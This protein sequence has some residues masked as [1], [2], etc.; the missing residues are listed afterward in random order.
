MA[1]PIVVACTHCGGN[2]KLKDASYVGKKIRCPKCQEPFVVKAAAAGK[3]A[4]GKSKQPEDEFGFLQG[5][6]E[7]DYEAP[8][9]PEGEA[10]EEFDD[11]PAT[12]SRKKSAGGKGKTAKKKRRASSGPELGRVAVIA[13]LIVL[14][15]L[16][17]GGGV[18]GVV[19]LV[20]NVGGGLGRLAWLPEDADF[21]CEVKVSELWNSPVLQPLTSGPAGESLAEQWK[22]VSKINITDIDRVVAGGRQSDAAPVVVMYAKTDLP[23][24]EIRKNTREVQHGGHTLY[25]DNVG[26]AGGFLPNGK[27][28]VYGPEGRLKSVIDRKGAGPSA[29]QFRQLPTTGQIA[30]LSTNP[31]SI[32]P[33]PGS[34]NPVAAMPLDQVNAASVA[35]AFQQNIDVSFSLDY[36]NAADAEKLVAEVD[37]KRSEALS[38]LESQRSMLQPNPFIDITKLQALLDAQQQILQSVSVTARGSGVTGKLTVPG[39]LLTDAS[40]MIGGMLPAMLP[41]QSTP[42]RRVSPPPTPPSSP[43]TTQSG[44]ESSDSPVLDP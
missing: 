22:S 19:K 1:A 31:G 16:V 40:E 3:R 8:P 13:G 32:R 37:Q 26:D 29:A 10:E 41:A 20:G 15:V 38:Q 25:M 30:L 9:P 27:T 39:R 28:F 6:S 2:L 21:V 24:E 12:R 14:G 43:G 36:A 11:L 7:D 18:Y 35:I 5:V 33:P 4:A 44:S 34:G 17:V 42:S 23:L